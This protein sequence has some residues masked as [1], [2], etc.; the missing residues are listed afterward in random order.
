MKS[1]RNVRS[2]TDVIP[3][4]GYELAR[5]Y[6]RLR[7]ARGLSRPSPRTWRR[8]IFAEKKRLLETGVDLF[9]LHALCVYLR[10]PNN[11]LAAERL[12]K[13]LEKRR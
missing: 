8:R 12:R 11:E 3:L 2:R 13:Q 6:W 1:F 9:V 7:A 5:L 10:R 4:W